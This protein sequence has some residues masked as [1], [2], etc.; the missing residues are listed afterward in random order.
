MFHATLISLGIHAKPIR[1]LNSA[2]KLNK[3]FR[4]AMAYLPKYLKSCVLMTTMHV[5][6][7]E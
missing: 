4:H 6:S 5:K 1:G 2:Q 7:R 3:I